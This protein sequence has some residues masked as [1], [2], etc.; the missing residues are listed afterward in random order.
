MSKYL[1]LLN[2]LYGSI[3]ILSCFKNNWLEV[4]LLKSSSCELFKSINL[5]DTLSDIEN[6]Y[7]KLW[8]ETIN[9]P[10]RTLL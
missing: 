8:D 4:C 7:G 10:S 9:N 1:L 2:V 5:T 6:R 3:L